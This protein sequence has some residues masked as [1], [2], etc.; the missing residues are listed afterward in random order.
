[1]AELGGK[2]KSKRRHERKQEGG[3]ESGGEESR[4]LAPASASPGQPGAE[5]GEGDLEK[6]LLGTC[7]V[8]APISANYN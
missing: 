8:F 2:S 7:P 6:L 1:M 3:G 5:A 4:E